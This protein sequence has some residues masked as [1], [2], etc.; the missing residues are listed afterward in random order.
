MPQALYFFLIPSGLDAILKVLPG[1]FLLR[2]PCPRTQTRHQGLSNMHG[3]SDHPTNLL[4][5]HFVA[6]YFAF[7]SVNGFGLQTIQFN[8]VKIGLLPRCSWRPCHWMIWTAWMLWSQHL[9]KWPLAHCHVRL[10]MKP[11]TRRGF[12]SYARMPDIPMHCDDFCWHL[13]PYIPLYTY[14][15]PVPGGEACSWPHTYLAAWH[16][17]NAGEEHETGAESKERQSNETH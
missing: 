3:V 8:Q 16:A 7:R 6:I 15:L 2:L 1:N 4:L 9:Q 17:H 11:P 14:D 13:S 12:A 5:T 10:W